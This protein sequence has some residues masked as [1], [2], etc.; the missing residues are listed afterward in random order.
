VSKVEFNEKQVTMSETL[1]SF[2]RSVN[3]WSSGGHDTFWLD[4]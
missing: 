1:S 2:S 3:V 4:R